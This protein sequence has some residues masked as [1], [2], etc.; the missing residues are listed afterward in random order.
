MAKSTSPSSLQIN[1]G[2]L[3][4]MENWK[5]FSD[6]E[7]NLILFLYLTFVKGYITYN[8]TADIV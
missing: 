2:L 1:S 8:D 3:K 5:N 7:F 6:T 4:L